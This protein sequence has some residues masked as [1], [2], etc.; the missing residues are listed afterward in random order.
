MSY[1]TVDLEGFTVGE[2]TNYWLA[3][4]VTGLGHPGLRTGDVPRG[5]QDG[6]VGANDYF[7]ARIIS[8]PVGFS[9]TT[10]AATMTLADALLDAWVP[11]DSDLTLTVALGPG[12]SFVFEGRPGADGQSPAELDLGELFHSPPVGK[13]LLTFRALDPG[14][15]VS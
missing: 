10:V 11:S 2:G 5:H 7:A 8:V 15:S 13:A 9:A 3:G 6:S 1:P 4:P 12:V 14:S